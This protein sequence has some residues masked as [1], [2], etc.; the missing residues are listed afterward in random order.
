MAAT[1]DTS[2][3]LNAADASG[4]AEQVPSLT[5]REVRFEHSRSLA[6][7]L[8]QVGATLL[9][10]TYQAGKLAA[11]GTSGGRL[12]QSFHNFD[13]PMGMAVEGDRIAVAARNQIWTLRNAA[14]V[15][16]RME[17]VGQFGACYLTRG[18]Q[19][20]GEI[21][22]HEL[23][24]GGDELWI[25]NTLFSCLCTLDQ[26]HSFVPRWCPRFI[27]RLAPEDRCHL[28]GLA[29][30]DGRPKYVTAMAPSDSAGGWRPT[31]VTS[32]CLIDVES[33]ETLATGLAM[34]HSPRVYRGRVW[35][36]DS[37]RGRL[38]CVDPATGQVET[39]GECPGYTRGLAFAGNFAFVGLSKIRET[40]TF[41][42]VPI[43]EDR[44]RL[45]CG[46]AVVE[47]SSGRVVSLFEFLSGVDEIFDVALVPGARMTALRGPFSR[48]EGEPTIWT[49]P[50]EAQDVSRLRLR[51]GG[52]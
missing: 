30:I 37:G 1:S 49:V 29:M 33:N 18:S 11:V 12:V 51:D 5:Q 4:D 20:T 42:G 35:L 52:S 14:D 25:V 39:V 3:L 31:K 28:N 6:P 41:G 7:L 23:G 8:E 36:L 10:S 34:P 26:R 17:P 22:A 2:L 45:K 38:V 21:Q 16:G 40:S 50:G 43:A 19:V 32:G 48:E 13:R 9:I 27:T 46:V 15:A 44:A 24:W 47:L